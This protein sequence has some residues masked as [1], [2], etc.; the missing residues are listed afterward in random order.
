VNW[1]SEKFGSGRVSLS[2][3]VKNGVK[4]AVK[5]IN[6]FEKVVVDIASKKGYDYVVCG[7]IHQ[8]Q[9]KM[10]ETDK[11][12]ILYL[13][14]GDWIENL[15]ALEYNNGKWRIYSFNDDKEAQNQIINET[16]PAYLN[17]GQLFKNL[18]HEFLS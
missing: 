5:Y 14:S 18:Q 6:D 8:P 17:P 1:V 16:T 12:A 13:N 3:Q 9:M 2:K 11:K 4:S 15:T 7:H 10:H